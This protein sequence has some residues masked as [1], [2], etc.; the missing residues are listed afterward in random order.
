MSACRGKKRKLNSS[1]AYSVWKDE[2]RLIKE[3]NIDQYLDSGF[4]PDNSGIF[5]SKLNEDLPVFGPIGDCEKLITRTNTVDPVSGMGGPAGS[6]ILLTRDNHGHRATGL[7]G[8]GATSCEAIDIVAG[9]LSAEK[10]LKTGGCKSRANFVTD[11]ARIYLTERGDIQN[12]FCL[13]EASS[14]TSVSS[15]LKSGIG[16]KADHT[17]IIGRELV[18]IVAGLGNAVGGERM[19]NMQDTN[20]GLQPRIEI[21]ATND[22]KAQPAVLGDALVEHLTDI[23]EEFMRVNNKIQK[24]ETD[25]IN[26]KYILAS[27][28]HQGAGVGV[29]N[30]FPEPQTI[31]AALKSVGTYFNATTENIIDAINAELKVFKWRGMMDKNAK[32]IINPPGD[33]ALL[34][35]TVY[36]GR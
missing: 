20:S 22:K 6:R 11:G 8:M 2:D 23:K 7:G 12:Y 31:G 9:S 25:L 24:I 35:R 28:F 21:A 33:S 26:Y 29:I 14:A 34:S 15:K 16:I 4:L 1:D 30:T 18:R 27:H 5:L 10:R 13:G 19:V 36:I 3:K 32:A 17:L